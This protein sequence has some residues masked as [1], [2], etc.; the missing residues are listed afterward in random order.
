MRSQT[1]EFWDTLQGLAELKA[2]S[3][4]AADG[5]TSAVC[6]QLPLLAVF[7]VHKLFAQGSTSIMSAFGT[8]SRCI[9]LLHRVFAGPDAVTESSQSVRGERPLQNSML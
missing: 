6:R 5:N 3:G 9:S 2:T 4:A 7:H 8:V 1:L